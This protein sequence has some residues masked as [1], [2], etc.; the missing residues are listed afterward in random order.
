MIDVAANYR[1]IVD[2]MNE[3]AAKGGRDARAIRLLAAAK[4]QSVDLM[5]AAIE[6]GV[7]LIG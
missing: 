3:A 2:R 4:S 6:A 7:V 1:K 5:Q